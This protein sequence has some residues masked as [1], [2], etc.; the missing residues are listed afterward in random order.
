MHPTDCLHTCIPGMETAYTHASQACK[1][2]G[3]FKQVPW[4]FHQIWAGE[5]FRTRSIIINQAHLRRFVVTYVCIHRFIQLHY[6]WDHCVTVVTFANMTVLI[7]NKQWILT[8]NT[9]TL[10]SFLC[11]PAIWPSY[12]KGLWIQ[13]FWEES[14]KFSQFLDLH[15]KVHSWPQNFHSHSWGV[16]VTWQSWRFI[17]WEPTAVPMSTH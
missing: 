17:W 7:H 4:P 9:S 12:S 16:S 15:H 8:L 1:Y 10:T 11:S 14:M 5:S 6:M 3:F 13:S 2:E